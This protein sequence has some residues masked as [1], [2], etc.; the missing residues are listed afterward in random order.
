MSLSTP[1]SESSSESLP[2]RTL[3]FSLCIPHPSHCRAHAA[4]AHL[5]RRHGY[6][7]TY[8]RNFTD[9]DDKIIKRANEVSE[10]VVD[11]RCLFPSPLSPVRPSRATYATTRSPQ[12]GKPCSEITE[13]FIGE[14][15]ADMT[16][17]GCLPPTF[18]PRATEHVEDIVK[19]IER[20][21]KN[22][23]AYAVDRDVYFD[24]DSLPGCACPPSPRVISP[25]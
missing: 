19:L 15:H 4:S 14:F 5:P 7:V 22:G 9:I 3:C 11:A 6:D 20:I 13:R 1:S 21:I 17:L 25:P 18:E 2:P 16:S 10:L 23:H 8:C 12:V 24:V